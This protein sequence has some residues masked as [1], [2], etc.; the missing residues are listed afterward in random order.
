[1]PDKLKA[2]VNPTFLQ[3]IGALS[4]DEMNDLRIRLKAAST[5]ASPEDILKELGG[6]PALSTLADGGHDR[7]HDTHDRVSTTD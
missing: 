3:K 7:V 6:H 1:M 5:A 2:E 4:D